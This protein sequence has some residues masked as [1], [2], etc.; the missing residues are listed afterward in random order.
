MDLGAMTQAAF[1]ALLKRLQGTGYSK[2]DDSV[3]VAELEAIA[4]IA[5]MTSDS[6]DKAMRNFFIESADEVLDVMERTRF[7]LADSTLTTARRRARLLAFTQSVSKMVAARIANGFAAYLGATTG[8]T[9]APELSDAT[10][11][12]A[13][14]FSAFL[15]ARQEP[16][17]TLKQQRR[18]LD[19]ILARGLPSHAL[20]GQVSVGPALWGTTALE[21]YAIALAPDVVPPVQTKARAAAIEFYPGSVVTP[22]QWIE[23]QSSLMWKSHGFSLDTVDQ[24]R[25]FLFEGSIGAGG[26]VTIDGGISWENRLIQAWGVISAADTPDLSA[27]TTAEHAWLAPGKTGAAGAGYSHAFVALSGGNPGITAQIDGS[28]DLV[29]SNSGGATRYLKVLFRCS[30]VY[31]PA[32]TVDTQPWYSTTSINPAQLSEIHKAAM[33]SD[34]ASPET[35][36]GV[37]AGAIRRV[38]YTGS[39]FY[40]AED[41]A[42]QGAVLDSSEDW[43]NRYVLIAPI[44]NYGGV[45]GSPESY[46][47]TASSDGMRTRAFLVNAPRLFYT[48]SGVSP[49][50]A[51]AQPYQHADN[52]TLPSVWIF[53]DSSGNL[54][55]EMKATDSYN[56]SACLMAL[57]IATEQDDGTSV[58]TLPWLDVTQVQTLDLEQ[59]QN[60]GCFQQGMQGG[61]PRSTLADALGAELTSPPLGLIPEGHSPSRPVAYRRREML[62]AADDGTYEWRQKISGQRKRIVSVSI[63]PGATVYVDDFD[64]AGEVAPGV[65]DQLDF[66]DRMLWVEGRYSTTDIRI[67]AAVQADD[68]ASFGFYALMYTG[69]FHKA[70]VSASDGH[71]VTIASTLT[72]RFEFDRN[73]TGGLHSR[74]KFVNGTA[75]TYRINAT[76]E[77][78]GQLG[79]S[80]LRLAG[81]V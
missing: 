14:P 77:V 81:V 8:S 74:L 52:P 38:I 54:C 13:S 72:L 16:A 69:P 25:N 61:V 66:R 76:I 35:F 22:E 80:D 21:P 1:L 79:L 3:R 50:Q 73:H 33:V 45:V 31:Q 62:G 36:A 7:I 75:S 5:A 58:V 63:G 67:G 34:P 10:A 47:P 30:P 40:T 15:I 42:V 56:V 70:T 24:G 57:V 28:G 2:E 60:I 68:S 27:N 64:V 46:F 59:P 44:I 4:R 37:N 6:I 49:G 23:I 20:A 41:G 71:E 32:S 29:L 26:T 18:D 11:H 12:K 51:T 19:P 9:L 43:R 65:N 53:A 78:S 17:A 48:G 39:L 55:A